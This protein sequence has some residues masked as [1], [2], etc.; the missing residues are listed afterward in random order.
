M[1][2]IHIYSYS[3]GWSLTLEYCISSAAVARSWGDYFTYS[4]IQLGVEVPAWINKIPVG[5]VTSLS[6]MAS[7]IIIVC[8]VV[9]LFG[10]K[11]SSTFNVIITILNMFVLLFFIGVGACRVNPSNWLT[12]SGSFVP[13]GA[14]SLFQGAGTIFF[15]YIGFDMVCSLAEET[16]NPQRNMPRGII[17]SLAIVATV[18]VAVSLVVTGVVPF[19]DIADAQAPLALALE[20]TNLGWAAIVVNFGAVLGLTASIFTGLLGQPRIFYTIARDVRCHA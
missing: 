18:Y 11:T 6:L 17:G 7:L 19:L 4:L 8:T 16:K 2:I 20:K 13:Y 10:I 5:S 12:L 9:M 3:I 15:S 1:R 14:A